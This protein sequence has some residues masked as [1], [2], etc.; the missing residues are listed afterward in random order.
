MSEERPSYVVK[1]DEDN[2]DIEIA[3]SGMG[4]TV[5]IRDICS[6]AGIKYTN[7]PVQITSE[8]IEIDPPAPG[9]TGVT[10]PIKNIVD[11]YKS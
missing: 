11:F 6:L 5:P 10:I 2:V 3:E 4:M 8:G 9:E 7:Q 1:L